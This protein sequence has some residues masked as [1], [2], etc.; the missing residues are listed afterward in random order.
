MDFGTTI[1]ESAPVRVVINMPLVRAVPRGAEQVYLRHLNGVDIAN[2]FA[3]CTG[4]TWL[5]SRVAN[6]ILRQIEIDHRMV[7]CNTPEQESA[8]DDVD[9]LLNRVFRIDV[10]NYGFRFL[11]GAVGHHFPR[12]FAEIYATRVLFHNP[13]WCIFL[14]EYDADRDDD[15]VARGM[16]E[17]GQGMVY[18]AHCGGWVQIRA[19]HLYGPTMFHDVYCGC[20]LCWE[21]RARVCN[22][23][24]G[25]YDYLPSQLTGKY[26]SVPDCTGFELFD[27]MQAVDDEPSVT[28]VP[29]GLS[30]GNAESCCVCCE[31]VSE[32]DLQANTGCAHQMHF[33][34]LAQ[35]NGVSR[36]CPLCRSDINIGRAE[37]SVSVDFSVEYASTN[38]LGDLEYCDPI[39]YSKLVC[40]SDKQ[41]HCYILTESHLGAQY[42]MI[43]NIVQVLDMKTDQ[44]II[45]GVERYTHVC[46]GEIEIQI[47]SR[48]PLQVR[49]FVEEVVQAESSKCVGVFGLG[50]YGDI[51]P[52]RVLAEQ[53]VAKGYTVTTMFPKEFRSDHPFD[54][55][56]LREALMCSPAVLPSWR[57]L[58]C[59]MVIKAI[60]AQMEQV[61]AEATFDFVV[62]SPHF[63]TLEM[64]C[65]RRGFPCVV[66]RSIPAGVGATVFMEQ[67]TQWHTRWACMLEMFQTRAVELVT[68]ACEVVTGSD[69]RISVTTAPVVLTLAP[70]LD[71]RGVGSLVLEPSSG[72]NLSYDVFFGLGSMCDKAIEERYLKVF[73]RTNFRV[74]FQT[75]YWEGTKGSITFCRE[76][77]HDVVFKGTSLVV[78]HGGVGTIQTA[79]RHGCV[80]VVEPIWIDQLYW[81][82]QCKKKGYQV[83]LSPRSDV[84]LVELLRKWMGKR[85]K[86]IST[87]SVC[88]LA[89]YIEKMVP[90][91]VQCGTFIFSSSIPEIRPLEGVEKIVFGDARAQHVGLGHIT[92]DGQA[93]YIEVSI[94][95]GLLHLRV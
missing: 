36:T 48:T 82:T 80:V 5:H 22:A 67:K 95:E 13:G 57:Q 3:R 27:R 87:I 65:E 29:V 79:L 93:S 40:E 24:M 68:T 54:W 42:E 83:V 34:C 69:Q 1:T 18:R 33:H 41:Y 23:G 37:S 25:I 71:A 4:N 39:S 84:E 6:S 51:E 53:Y 10:H 66:Q 92:K 90:S 28:G 12:R 78:C 11:N 72:A 35:W 14:E 7:L 75:K 88:W 49:L 63:F 70:E 59:N 46:Q 76:V 20:E 19:M 9:S 91:P 52:L 86:R 38:I 81:P 16:N 44:V 58:G 17:L 32:D 64:L 73:S 15:D 26:D 50:T 60:I 94:K 31:I 43:G 45:K 30:F 2:L 56:E 62:A 47:V 55:G 61:L 21:M 77:N 85:Q 89:D 74:L 8:L